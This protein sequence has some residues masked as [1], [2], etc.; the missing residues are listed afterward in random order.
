[1]TTRDEIT[2]I[3]RELQAAEKA[4]AM[5]ERAKQ[6]VIKNLAPVGLPTKERPAPDSADIPNYIGLP[7]KQKKTENKW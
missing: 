5:S 7:K 3:R 2:K 6:P 1:M 4:L